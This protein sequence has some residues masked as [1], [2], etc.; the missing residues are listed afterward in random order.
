MY[1]YQARCQAHHIAQPQE[2]MRWSFDSQ[3]YPDPSHKP[4]EFPTFSSIRAYDSRPV[5]APCSLKRPSDTSTDQDTF[6]DRQAKASHNQVERK[7]RENLNFKFE[8]LR[9][10]IPSMQ[11]VPGGEVP[12]D[13]ADIGEL[14]KAPQKPRKAEILTSATI[15]M[16]QMEDTNR[17]LREKIESL[18]ARNQEL[19]KSNRCENCWLRSDFGNLTF[20]GVT[21]WADHNHVLSG[22]MERRCHGDAE[23]PSTISE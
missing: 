23:E 4:P 15:Y 18:T 10:A 5:L 7:Y 1:G 8:L 19:E 14:A 17:L 21:D 20:E 3:A 2:N 6:F 9:K 12:Q 22:D 16:K 13:G 11:T